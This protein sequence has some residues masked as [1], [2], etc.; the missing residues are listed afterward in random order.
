L[1]HYEQKVDLT[2]RELTKANTDARQVKI[3]NIADFLI[4]ATKRHGFFTQSGG[5]KKRLSARGKAV[6]E[7]LPDQGAVKEAL[8][9]H[10]LP[11]QT[12][13]RRKAKKTK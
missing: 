4:K 8:E 12:G 9:R 7:A 11:K 6:A 13:R 3:S 5:G 10:S 1:E 2:G